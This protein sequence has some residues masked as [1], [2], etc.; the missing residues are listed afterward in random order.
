M[1]ILSSLS[2]GVTE[3]GCHAGYDDGLATPYRVD[4]AIEV[5]TLCSPEIRKAITAIPQEFEKNGWRFW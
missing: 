4:R 3:L 1:Q 2:D 5:K